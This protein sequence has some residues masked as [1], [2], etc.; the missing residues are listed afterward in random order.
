MLISALLKANLS[1]AKEEVELFEAKIDAL[2]QDLENESAKQV[3]TPQRRTSLSL[4]QPKRG[5]L[6]DLKGEL[7]QHG[8][9]GPVVLE[10]KRRAVVLGHEASVRWTENLGMIF[11]HIVRASG[12]DTKELMSHLDIPEDYED[13]E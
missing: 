8:L 3:D 10:R 11:S 12:C 7:A 6:A 1:G 4:L 13:I 2:R 9:A 5:T